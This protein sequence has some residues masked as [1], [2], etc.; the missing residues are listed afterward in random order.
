M[1]IAHRRSKNVSDTNLTIP[2]S[3][4]TAVLGIVACAAACLLFGSAAFAQ[5]T[6]TAQPAADPNAAA[7][8]AAAQPAA[9]PNTAA[10]PAADPNTAA[11]PAPAQPVAAQPAPAQPV[12]AQPAP[13]QPVAA[14]PAPAQ[15][16]AAQPAP[17]QPVAAQPAPAQPVAAQPAPAQPVAVQSAPAQPVAAQPQTVSKTIVTAQDGSQLICDNINGTIT[18]CQAQVQQ[19]VYPKVTVTNP[20]G[21]TMLCDNINGTIA[22]CVTQSV[23]RQQVVAAPQPQVVYTQPQQPAQVVIVQT[24]PP[25]EE[26]S[27]FK[28]GN[29]FLRG[30]V[31]YLHAFYVYMIEKGLSTNF[32]YGFNID[33]TAGYLFKYTGI[34]TSLDIGYGWASGTAEEFFGVNGD[35]FNYEGKSYKFDE[36]HL[37]GLF[38]NWSIGPA[39]H[40]STKVMD[41]K[42]LYGLG[43]SHIELIY[44][45]KLEA[46]GFNYETMKEDGTKTVS[47]RQI[48]DNFFMMKFDI[49]L[50]FWVNE[51]SAV[52]IDFS[53]FYVMGGLHD[54]YP[55]TA[56]MHLISGALS[57]TYQF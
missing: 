9:D 7:Q 26:E 25:A 45:Y 53:W 28:P 1:M 40:Y 15:P 21:S 57:Y 27:G 46:G 24:Q 42:F 31:G 50:D 11:Q 23:P 32:G 37:N 34:Y 18:N 19:P 47:G 4:R 44:D 54:D 3:C 48:D 35:T 12:A 51:H 55:D 33:V 49:G 36:K 16:V 56:D 39:L 5:D 14:Q 20:D 10:Q 38:V 22:N 8:P 29:F 43:V 17:A 52:G 2:A 6:A 13:A 41:F 30:N